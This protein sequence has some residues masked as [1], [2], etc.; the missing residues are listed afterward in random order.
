MYEDLANGA[1]KCRGIRAAI[2]KALEQQDVE[3]A[4]ILY[5]E[6]IEEDT[7]YGDGFQA[8]VVF[9]EYLS[10]FDSHPEYHE[11]YSYNLMWA[12]KWVLSCVEDFYQIPLS[13]IVDMYRQYGDYCDKLNYNKRTYYRKLWN[14]MCNYGLRSLHIC[15]SVEEAHKLMMHCPLDR[16]SEVAA[17]EADDLTSYY[18]EIE[19]NIDK[20]LKAAEPI[21]SGKVTCNVVPHYTYD[22][23]AMYYFYHKD[24]EKAE[25]YAKKSMQLINRD[26]G[27]D[28]SLMEHKGKIIMILAYTDLPA[29][30]KFFRRQIKPCS[31]NEC[32]WDNFHFNRGAYHLM[33]CLRESGEETVRVIL[34]YTDD[35]IF[36]EDNIYPAAELEKYYYDKA[37]FIADR[38]DERDNNHHFNYL[39]SK[40]F[41]K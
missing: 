32:G 28:K 16:L 31:T 38:F 8:A 41:S 40:N 18:L 39:L 4:L 11:Q 25:K 34:P 19:K 22:N 3:N 23:F 36:R 17:G 37:K 7:F 21:F 12:F 20:A 29:A 2:D 14:L 13:Q 15:S 33:K 26:F 10:C 9:P 5:Y 24:F 30:L 1:P 27:T 35:P 6:Y